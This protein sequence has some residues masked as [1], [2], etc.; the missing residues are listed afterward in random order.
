MSGIQPKMGCRG[1]LLVAM[2]LSTYA[3][4]F[5]D[6]TIPITFSS[7][8]MVCGN[9]P[10]A[11]GVDEAEVT[12]EASH[13]GT[14]ICERMPMVQNATIVCGGGCAR[15]ESACHAHSSC[16]LMY[17]LGDA[18]VVRAT[19]VSLLNLSS[20]RLTNGR[21]KANVP[22]VRASGGSGSEETYRDVHAVCTRVGMTDLAKAVWV[23]EFTRHAGWAAIWLWSQ[24]R[25]LS[26]ATYDVMC[27]H[28]DDHMVV[29]GSCR[30]EFAATSDTVI[31][32]IK[33]VA[34]YVW[35]GIMYATIFAILAFSLM[36]DYIHLLIKK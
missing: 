23:C 17:R 36:C 24:R 6:T 7:T 35:W 3:R 15:E 8:Q 30:V 20:L 21:R 25:E 10:I 34:S 18:R 32:I 22:Q 5:V 27:E 4:G 33:S 16:R 19:E 11:G 26:V 2:L 9:C 1:G 13:G 29:A 28:V 31:D 12:C 14:W